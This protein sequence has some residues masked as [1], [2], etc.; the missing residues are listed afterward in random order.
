MAVAVVSASV[1]VVLFSSLFPHE[2]KRKGIAVQHSKKKK[3]RDFMFCF[4]I[5]R[6]VERKEYARGKEG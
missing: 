4:L 1:V 3:L 6:K 2:E 5:F